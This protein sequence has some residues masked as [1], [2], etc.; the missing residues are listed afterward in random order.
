[1]KLYKKLV[2]TV[3][4]LAVIPVT[5]IFTVLALPYLWLSEENSVGIHEFLMEPFDQLKRI[6]S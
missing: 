2:G 5:V 3:I 6:W 4:C 1:M